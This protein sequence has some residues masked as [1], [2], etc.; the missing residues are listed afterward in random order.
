MK[1]RFENACEPQEG[2]HSVVDT[3]LH[4][5]APGKLC[6][7]VVQDNTEHQTQ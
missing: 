6:A 7:T 1:H 4:P 5:W 2:N 3:G